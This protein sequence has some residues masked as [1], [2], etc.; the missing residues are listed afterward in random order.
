[1]NDTSNREFDYNSDATTEVYEIHGDMESSLPQQTPSTPS[2]PSASFITPIRRTAMRYLKRA[3]STNPKQPKKPKNKRF[4]NT[5]GQTISLICMD[6]YNKYKKMVDENKLRCCCYDDDY[7][8]CYCFYNSYHSY[9]HTQCNKDILIE[10]V[11]LVYRANIRKIELTFVIIPKTKHVISTS[12]IRHECKITH[13]R[14]IK[15]KSKYIDVKAFSKFYE[16][17]KSTIKMITTCN[18]CFNVIN[19]ENNMG[20]RC[21]K[22]KWIDEFNVDYNIEDACAICQEVFNKNDGIAIT[23]CNHYFHIACLNETQ[24]LLCPV[25]RARI[26]TFKRVGNNQVYQLI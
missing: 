22:C 1:M 5:S 9:I 13:C 12:L 2:T 15:C 7:D 4:S 25:C 26:N 6:L 24:Q 23:S 11:T 14:Y 3:S 20:N 19:P 18:K 16:K 10:S 21:D 17:L 8:A